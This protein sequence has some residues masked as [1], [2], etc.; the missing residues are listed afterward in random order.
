M[1]KNK[2]SK[3]DQIAQFTKKR[4][5]VF[6]YAS[7]FTLVMIAITGGIGY[8]LDQQL[9]TSPVFLVIGLVIGYPITQLMLY[10]KYKAAIK[11]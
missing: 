9:N 4:V 2:M 11:K 8:L 5:Q 6:V 7:M 3:D 10:K 1:I